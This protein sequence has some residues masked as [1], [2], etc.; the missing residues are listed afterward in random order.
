MILCLSILQEDLAALLM[1]IDYGIHC[2]IFVFHYPRVNATERAN[3]YALKKGPS[4]NVLKESIVE[5]FG[6]LLHQD[7]RRTQFL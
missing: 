1:Q 5:L 4:Y 6:Q 3:F 7:G 2:I